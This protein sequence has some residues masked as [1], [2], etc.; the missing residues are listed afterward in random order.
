MTFFQIADEYERDFEELEVR[1]LEQCAYATLLYVQMGHKCA[2]RMTDGRMDRAMLAKRLAAWPKERFEAAAR[3]LVALGQ[4]RETSDGYEFVDWDMTQFSKEQ[5]LRRRANARERQRRR[6]AR[7][8]EEA[9]SRDVTQPVTPQSG[10]YEIPRDETIRESTNVTR[11]VTLPS[12]SP[13]GSD[14]LSEDQGA[15]PAAAH[16]PAA[17]DQVTETRVRPLAKAK[18]TR[19]PQPLD[20]PRERA[21]E[22]FN[23]LWSPTR[24]GRAK[25]VPKSGEF[26]QLT[27]MVRCYLADDGSLNEP[28]Y[29]QALRGFLADESQ[30]GYG[31]WTPA[32]FLRN[33]F[34]GLTGARATGTGC[35]YAGF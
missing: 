25:W 3:E 26:G 33:H 1:D 32:S 27:A 9:A 10:V 4:W 24:G 13:L 22:L 31:Q 17:N 35:A 6:R 34:R 11:D 28:V 5:E 29:L 30:R 15:P 14:L 2:S 16:P 21:V 7:L 12:A 18:R 19:A 20:A 8:A 23:E